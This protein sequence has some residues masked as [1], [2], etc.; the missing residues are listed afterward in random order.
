MAWE[1]R[2]TFEQ[3]E[4]RYGL[5]EADV[6]KIMRQDLKRSSFRLWRERVSGRLTKHGKKFHRSREQLKRSLSTEL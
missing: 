6:I 4:K 3:I 5:K 2:T 1:D